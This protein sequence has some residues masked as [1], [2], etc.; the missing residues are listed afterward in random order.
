MTGNVGVLRAL[1]QSR[2]LLRPHSSH[3]LRSCGKIADHS[4]LRLRRP[5]PAGYGKPLVPLSGTAQPKWLVLSLA[6][7]KAEPFRRSGGRAAIF[8]V[9]LGLIALVFAPPSSS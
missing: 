5:A 6:C 9:V 3:R 8:S 1:R 2:G 4:L 7:G